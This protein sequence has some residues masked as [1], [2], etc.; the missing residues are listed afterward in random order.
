M[1]PE[2]IQGYILSSERRLRIASS[3]GEA[4]LEARRKLIERFLG[5]LNDLVIGKLK[6]W[7]SE[8]YQE[9]FVGSEP[10][11]AFWKP[12]WEG[13]CF[14][15]LHC[16]SSG[17]KMAFGIMREVRFKD[18]KKTCPNLFQTVQKSFPTARSNRWWEAM[19]AMDDPAEDWT[20]PDVLWRLH[21]D[22]A[23]LTSVAGQILEMAKICEP[24]IDR[25]TKKKTK[26]SH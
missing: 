13:R 17:R 10:N 21:T 1:N 6:G 23:F 12:A 4:W 15:A 7:K 25:W 2:S 16:G 5:E 19:V 14:L 18:F 3:V 24:L 9:F 26:H 22:K 8:P 11:Y 20:K